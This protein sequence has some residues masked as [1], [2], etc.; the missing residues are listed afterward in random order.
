MILIAEDT[1]RPFPWRRVF[2]VTPHTKHIQLLI[3]LESDRL[4]EILATDAAGILRGHVLILA[5]T[6]AETVATSGVRAGAYC[7]T[8]P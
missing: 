7:W 6:A 4:I 2:R 8:R 1:H 3:A 5:R